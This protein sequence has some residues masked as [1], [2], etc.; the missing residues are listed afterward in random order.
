MLVAIWLFACTSE[1]DVGACREGFIREPDGHCYPPVPEEPEGVT[2]EDAL[3]WLPACEPIQEPQGLIDIALGCASGVCAGLTEPE[4]TAAYGEPPTC[5]PVSD[6]D[7]RLYCSWETG[8][9]GLFGDED[10]DGWPD[11]HAPNARTR[12]YPPY[13]GA[14]A[15]GLGVGVQPS[16]FLDVLGSPDRLIFR[17][18]GGNLLIQEMLWDRYGLLLY[19][20]GADD[21]TNRPNGLIDYVYLY[22]ATL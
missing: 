9:E 2:I 3:D 13:R 21:F 18:V 5:R 4:I 19:D 14:T 16:C 6:H 7:P 8:L 15:D 12:L 22:G 11:P 20:L 17:D 10:G 1:P